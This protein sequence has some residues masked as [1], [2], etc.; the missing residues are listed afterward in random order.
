MRALQQAAR[1]ARRHARH[2]RNTTHIY[3]LCVGVRANVRCGAAGAVRVVRNTHN[4][5]ICVVLLPFPSTRGA[6]AL[7]LAC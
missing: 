1:A 2:A 4:T 6:P 3:V 5:Y 7:P